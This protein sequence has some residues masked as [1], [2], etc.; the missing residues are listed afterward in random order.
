[1]GVLNAR[2]IEILLP[3]WAFFLQGRGTIADFDPSRGFVW[4]KAGIFH[5]SEVFAFGDGTF[6]QSLIVDSFQ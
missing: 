5:I 1:M 2:Q 6:T 3:V 4:A